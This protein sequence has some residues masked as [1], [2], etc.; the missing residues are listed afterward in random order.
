MIHSKHALCPTSKSTLL[1]YPDFSK[2]FVIHTD[3]SH[4]QLGA[5]IL[6]DG[7]PIAFY[8]QKLNPALTCYT[9][10]ECELLSIVEML[11]EF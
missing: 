3:A 9:T 5:V 7:K 1:A 11:K 4:M 2:K 6:Q 10:T 8:S